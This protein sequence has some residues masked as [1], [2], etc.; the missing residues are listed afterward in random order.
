[1]EWWETGVKKEGSEYIGFCTIKRKDRVKETTIEAWFNEYNQGNNMWKTKPRTMIR[2]VAIAQAFR[3]VFPDELGGLPYTADEIEA[4]GQ[5]IDMQPEQELTRVDQMIKSLHAAGKLGN[6]EKFVGKPSS[7][8]TEADIDKIESAKR[9]NSKKEAPQSPPV[10][11]EDET[12]AI[13]PLVANFALCETPE[14][15]KA[16]TEQYM[17]EMPN[18]TPEQDKELEAAH[19][20]AKER[21]GI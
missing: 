21:L 17:A 14:A 6:A 15:F 19:D 5:I 18:L 9:Q 2:K 3:M 13:H 1:L 11:A 4:H 16:I 12:K 7:E 10:P 8:W 20:A